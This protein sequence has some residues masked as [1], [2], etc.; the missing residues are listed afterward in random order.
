MEITLTATPLNDVVTVIQREIGALA[1]N[2]IVHCFQDK[3]EIRIRR[4]H[5]SADGCLAHPGFARRESSAI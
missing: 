4:V 5:H 2:E 3:E 1:L